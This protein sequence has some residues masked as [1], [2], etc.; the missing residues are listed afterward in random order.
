MYRL[1]MIS[2]AGCAPRWAM[3]A[4]AVQ[5]RAFSRAACKTVATVRHRSAAVTPA[6]HEPRQ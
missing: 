4:A 5:A 3:L 1:R 2:R 6:K